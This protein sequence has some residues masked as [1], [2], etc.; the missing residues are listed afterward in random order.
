[1]II[2]LTTFRKKWSFVYWNISSGFNKCRGGI[3]QYSNRSVQLTEWSNLLNISIES[4]ILSS[5][6]SLRTCLQSCTCTCL[7]ILSFFGFQDVGSFLHVICNVWY[8]DCGVL[9]PCLVYWPLQI[10]FFE[11][12]A[13]VLVT[14]TLQSLRRWM[15]IMR[16]LNFTAGILFTSERW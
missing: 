2:F 3:S 15:L 14:C 5:V 7:H 13:V 11:H 4:H 6:Q 10:W 12:T 1:M 8:N 16:I 9:T